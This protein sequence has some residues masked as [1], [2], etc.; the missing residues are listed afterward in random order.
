MLTKAN[1]MR[2]GQGRGYGEIDDNIF[3]EDN[4]EKPT[5][6][7]LPPKKAKKM[8]II[9]THA[10]ALACGDC[11]ILSGL[12]R[13]LQGP[14]SFPYIPCGDASGIV[15]EIPKNVDTDF[16]F[17]VG[18]RVAAR[19]VE[20]PSNAL[21]E[22]ALISHAVCEKVPAHISFVDAAALAS[23]SPAVLL[24][25][26]IREG[27]RVLVLGAGGGVGSHA[28]QLMKAQGA[29]FVAGVSEAP[30]R[31]LASPLKYDRAI[32]Y[33]KTDIF[34]LQEF[35]DKPF[36]TI[37]DL[38][39]GGWL[40]LI[41]S[42]DAKTKSIIKPATEGGRFLTVTPDTAI[43]EAHSVPAIMKIFLWIPI[44]R[45]IKSRT[46]G[47]RNLPSYTFAMSLP[48]DRSVMTKTMNLASKGMDVCQNSR[49][50]FSP[51][52]TESFFAGTLKAVI[53]PKGERS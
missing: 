27:E 10:V 26:R 41:K 28:C 8:M 34:T 11:R 37:L 40:K 3:V 16:P 44:W 21:A 2:A 47:R 4:I 31:L 7:D 29:S 24:A 52:L 32:D 51:I 49:N 17:K 36:D 33:T 45:A 12:T 5:L 30:D 9:K 19:F 35:K 50:F 48:G 15:E 20:G 13:E 1:K 25:E 22:Y 53:D 42:N 14:P 23:A 43:F 38:S 18:D 46:W 39:A 6:K